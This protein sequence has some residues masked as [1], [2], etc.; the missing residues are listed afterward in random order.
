MP[1]GSFA[2]V[3]VCVCQSRHDLL[4]ISRQREGGQSSQ[5]PGITRSGQSSQKVRVLSGYQR[6]PWEL[7][8]ANHD[9][10]GLQ[11]LTV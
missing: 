6:A 8:L 5:K 2:F 3:C 11:E 1:V 10:I 9:Q 4:R 7:D